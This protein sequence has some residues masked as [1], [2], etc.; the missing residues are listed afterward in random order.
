MV[1]LDLSGLDASSIKRN[2]EDF[3]NEI[4][5]T[6]SF[7]LPTTVDVSS[8]WL[9]FILFWFLTSIIS[10]RF[11]GNYVSDAFSS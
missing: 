6:T 2:T 1:K 11:R 10:P 3:H 5:A 4:L 8:T 7:A 9:H